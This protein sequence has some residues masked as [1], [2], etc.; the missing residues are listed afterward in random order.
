VSSSN[1]NFHLEFGS[2]LEAI[3]KNLEFFKLQKMTL[4]EVNRIY[5]QQENHINY[6]GSGKIPLKIRIA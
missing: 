5:R 2:F 3:Q 1:G 6:L 4:W